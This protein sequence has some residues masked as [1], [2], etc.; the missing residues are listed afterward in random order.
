MKKHEHIMFKKKRKSGPAEEVVIDGAFGKQIPDNF[1]NVY[2]ELFNR[3]SDG[4]IVKEI[5]DNINIGLDDG[6]MREINKVNICSI[7]DAMDKI[8]PSK[9][10][11]TWNLTS[12]FFK[13]GPEIFLKL[14]NSSNLL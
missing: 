4:D 9:S 14:S 6:S 8:K 7:K 5:L 3:E 2:E 10:D 11:S 1:A 13:N 12:D